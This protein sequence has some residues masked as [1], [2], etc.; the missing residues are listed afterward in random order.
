MEALPSKLSCMLYDVPSW[1][2][3]K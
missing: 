3:W 2:L 1:H